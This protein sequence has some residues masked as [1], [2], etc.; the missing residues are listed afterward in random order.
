MLVTSNFSF[1]HSVFKRLV[2]QT[3]KNK[4]LFGKGLIFPQTIPGL[5]DPTFK[6]PSENIVENGENAGIFSFF[7]KVFLP[8][9]DRNHH[10]TL[11][12]KTNF[13]LFLTERVCRWQFW[14]WQKWQKV[15]QMG[16]KHCGKRRNC[17]PRA[18]SPFPALFSKDLYCI[19]VKTRVCL[20]N[21]YATFNMLS[22]NLFNLFK[23]RIL[24]FEKELITFT[25]KFQPRPGGSVVSVLDLW[26][27]GCEFNPRLRQLFFPAYFRLSPLQKHVRK[28]VSGFG[29]K[30]VST[31]VRKPG[32]TYASPTAMIWP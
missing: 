12:Q 32:N 5:H 30:S 8:C 20:G 25:C 1:S 27:G 6:K 3:H 15:L 29:K 21:A 9:W 14:I 11:S 22:A 18:I 7:H 4:G 19:Y 16:G 10:L 31:G 2:L 17:L 23:V 13:R 28:V 26:P 24:S